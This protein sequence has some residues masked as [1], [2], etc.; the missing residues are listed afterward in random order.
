VYLG[1]APLHFEYIYIMKKILILEEF[2]EIRGYL[3][4]YILVGGIESIAI[5]F[6]IK[7][8]ILGFNFVSGRLKK[9]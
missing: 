9:N 1:C 8:L 3:W 7:E 2:K 5:D 4:K 6:I